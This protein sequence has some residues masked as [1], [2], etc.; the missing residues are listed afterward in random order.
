VIES[1][2]QLFIRVAHAIAGV[3]KSYEKNDAEVERIE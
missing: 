2:K 1:P 3:E